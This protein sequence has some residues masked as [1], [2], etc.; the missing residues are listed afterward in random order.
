MADQFAELARRF[1]RRA[2]LTQEALAERSG[3]SVRTIRGLET[4]KRA[5]P[6]L[7]TV[8]LLAQALGLSPAEQDE[9]TAAT[10]G[11][12]R[13]V[14]RQLPAVPRWFTGR[15][16]ELGT[17]DHLT[18]TA[19][20]S[21][22]GGVGKS[23]LAVHWA[24]RNADRFPDGQLF[25]N[26]RGFDPS[27][28]PLAATTALR[29]F[30]Q[31]LGVD[32]PD[33][34]PD[35]DAQAALFRSLT[36][37]RRMLIVLDNA[38]STAQVT[39]LLPSGGSAVLVT[40]RHR[41]AALVTAHGAVPVPLDT[42]P[43]DDART[44]L[45]ER[46]G[47]ERVAA[48]PDAVNDLIALCAGLPLALGIVAGRAHTRPAFP[49]AAF[50]TQLHDTTTR[51][52]E[53]DDGDPATS[54]RAV[55]SWSTAA[56]TEEQ[57]TMFAL[58]GSA[59]GPDI[60]AVSAACLA[61]LTLQRATAVLRALERASLLQEHL[62]GRYRMCDLVRLHAAELDLPEEERKATTR[63]LINLHTHSAESSAKLTWPYRRPSPLGPVPPS[64]YS[65]V[66]GDVEAAVGWF[67]AERMCLGATVQA[68]AALGQHTHVWQLAR[69]LSPFYDR[70]GFL[71]ESADVWRLALIAAHHL[72]N[73]GVLA[74]TYIALGF[75]S[76]QIGLL[77]EAH[78][79]LGQGLR[80]AIDEGDKAQ[81]GI[82]ENMMSHVIEWQ[83]DLAVA[84]EHAKRS[85]VIF[86]QL[87]N[88]VFE[89]QSLSQVGWLA[90]RTGD[91]D[92]A[93]EACETA[94]KVFQ[95]RDDKDSQSVVTHTLG[96]IARAAGRL[97]DA[98]ELYQRSC[99]LA[100]EIGSS[101]REATNTEE[102]GELHAE[103]G[104]IAAA[105]TAWEHALRLMR[106][107]HRLADAERVEQRLN[108]LDDS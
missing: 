31:A 36:A 12:D 4:G 13:T 52:G 24:H 1:R 76:G 84:L 61:A 58:L 49:L 102:L 19:V 103:F 74:D 28:S 34:P 14:P 40:S 107:Q 3:V 95:D 8:R 90:A 100:Q 32:H 23:T 27:G 88:E 108:G 10:E 51:L 56:L 77:E 9:L 59:P 15:T 86:Q 21:G 73:A 41:L 63:R 11:V 25:V 47:A 67:R 16:S 46:V 75:N 35:L 69:H 93:Q 54:V 45:A 83:G 94:L 96:F 2:G 104:D 5:N 22:T 43:D 48:E 89:A 79:L 55:L 37:D 85:H 66:P 99:D 98:R 105:H 50:A 20:I 60:S 6:Q 38:A 62:P 29:G 71:Q 82:A 92:T 39:P 81:E 26:L 65:Q 17:L 7:A 78:G 30:L 70:A 44:L 80:L 42:L 87:D 33:I 53:L 97:A 72:G 101:R 64:A 91:H 106:E 57:T 18:G 68:A